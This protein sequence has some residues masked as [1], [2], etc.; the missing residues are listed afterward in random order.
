M[1]LKQ[2]QELVNLLSLY[3]NELL[4]INEDNI[5][6][7]FSNKIINQ[8]KSDGTYDIKIDGRCEFYNKG[9]KGKYEHARIIMTKLMSEINNKILTENDLYYSER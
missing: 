2:K 8:K 3:C 9:I 4:D 6:K 5:K 7:N 1:T